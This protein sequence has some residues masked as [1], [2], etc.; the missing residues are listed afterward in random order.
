M[1]FNTQRA[2]EL[3]FIAG[4]RDA[5]GVLDLVQ[6][7]FSKDAVVAEAAAQTVDRVV[8]RCE[9][10]ELLRLDGLIRERSEWRWPDATPEQLIGFSRG[11]VGMLGVLSSHPNGHVREAALRAL[12]G[13][14]VG[15]EL[16]F[17]LIRLNDWVPQVRLAARQA[18]LDRIHPEHARHFIQYLPLVF[19]L[20]RVERSDAREVV[21]SV[22]ALLARPESREALQHAM[23]NGD[24]HVRRAALRTSISASDDSARQA[25]ELGLGSRDTVIRLMA[26]REARVRFNERELEAALSRMLQ[27][28]FMP[29]RREA[30]YGYFARL[31]QA[32]AER[33]EASLFD[34]HASIRETARF[35]LRKLSERDPAGPY[36]ARLGDANSSDLAVAIAGLGETGMAA[37]AAPLEGFLAHSSAAV[38]RETMRALGRLDASRYGEQFFAALT[39]PAAGVVKA[40]RQIVRRQLFGIPPERLESIFQSTTQPHSRR[41]VLSL[42]A[43][44]NWWD[45]AAILTT[46]VGTAEEELK[47]RALEFL[48]RWLAN[49][50]RSTFRPAPEQIARLTQARQ[51]FGPSLDQALLADLDVHLDYVLQQVAE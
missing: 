26:A 32:A 3:R 34:A 24:R 47:Q 23:T 31:P 30:L 39:D 27:D 18:V 1:W 37:D 12:A 22:L 49:P 29:V 33:F 41:A 13:G 4:V 9:S 11:F 5:R 7:V 20:E 28:R 16:G 14:Q 17:L 2:H 43:E 40:A 36:R 42:I 15:S 21:E 10:A 6:L 35:F 50:R 25:I 19:R 45:G 8:G 46:I 51:Q 38:R 48:R 44:L